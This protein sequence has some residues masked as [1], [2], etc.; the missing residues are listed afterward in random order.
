[1][2]PVRVATR[3]ER[4]GDDRTASIRGYRSKDH[5]LHAL[6]RASKDHY[7]LRSILPSS[8]VTIKDWRISRNALQAL[9]DLPQSSPQGPLLRLLPQIL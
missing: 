6:Q 8:D 3:G 4:G 9:F 7:M 5:A 1:M 2:I